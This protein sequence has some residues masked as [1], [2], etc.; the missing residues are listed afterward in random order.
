MTDREIGNE[1]THNVA[2]RGVLSLASNRAGIGAVSCVSEVESPPRTIGA[3]RTAATPC[4]VSPSLGRSTEPA[5]SAGASMARRNKVAVVVP[6]VHI[7][8]DDDQVHLELTALLS[9]AGHKV[10]VYSSREFLTQ[11]KPSA[12]GCVVLDVRLPGLCGLEMLRFLNRSGFTLPVIFVTANGDVQTAVRAMK[13]GAF[14]FIQKPVA[15]HEILKHI[16]HALQQN[17]N[18][19]RILSRRAEVIRRI[20]SLTPRERQVMAMVLEGATN[21]AI[22]IDLTISERTVEI[23]RARVMGKTGAQSVAHLMKLQLSLLPLCACDGSSTA[24]MG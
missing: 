9:A 8:Q 2:L 13:E 5:R 17:E 3:G 10:V 15:D 16:H 11:L 19:R 18:D 21:K 24:S 1:L 6:V 12:E 14:E 20:E 4:R 7:F 22:G 23:H